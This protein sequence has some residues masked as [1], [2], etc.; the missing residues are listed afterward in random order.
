MIVLGESG[1]LEGSVV[2][3]KALYLRLP[4]LLLVLGFACSC[5]PFSTCLGVIMRIDFCCMWSVESLRLGSFVLSPDSLGEP[6]HE[7]RFS[8]Y[9]AAY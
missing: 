6:D 7:K 1:V 8:V 9:E 4:I 5:L 3:G 2:L